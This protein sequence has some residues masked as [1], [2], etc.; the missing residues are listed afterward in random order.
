MGTRRTNA[1]RSE[2]TRAALVAAA[3]ALF[4][5]RGYGATPTK[6]IVERARV[7]QG[8]LYYHFKDKAD[9]FYAV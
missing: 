2:E 7:T 1:E 9:L 4:T 3:R 5:E 8:A 6:A